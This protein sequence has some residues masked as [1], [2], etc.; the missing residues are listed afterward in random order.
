MQQLKKQ[1]DITGL[2]VYSMGSHTSKALRSY[3]CRHI[4]ELPRADKALFGS[5]IV[6]EEAHV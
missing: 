4:I 1:Q 6:E 5:C 3:G 2:P